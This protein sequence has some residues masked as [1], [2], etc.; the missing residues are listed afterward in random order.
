MSKYPKVVQKEKMGNY[1]AYVKSGGG[2]V[3]D[4][5]L[6]YRVWCYPEKGAPDYDNGDDYFY[7][8]D[9]YEDALEFSENNVGTT[10]PIA[11]I[12]Q[13]EYIDEPEP[14]HYIHIK[15]ERLTEWPVVFLNRPQR[16]ETTIPNFFSPNAPKNRLNILKGI[17]E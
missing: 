14:E 8:F 5:V 2:Y 7:V 12:L 15:E 13:K 4:E 9:T 16:I 1:P 17:E 3:W 10:P 11:L 6:E